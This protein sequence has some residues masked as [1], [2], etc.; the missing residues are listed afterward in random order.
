MQ[1]I[2][3][4]AIETIARQSSNSIGRPHRV[5]PKDNCCMHVDFRVAPNFSIVGHDDKDCKRKRGDDIKDEQSFSKRTVSYP[6]GK[7]SFND[8]IIIAGNKT[9]LC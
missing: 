1:D 8:V 7:N 5:H 3:I 6:S 4:S 2:L 9:N